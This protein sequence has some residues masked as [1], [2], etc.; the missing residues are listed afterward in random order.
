MIG[1]II[2]YADAPYACGAGL[3][4]DIYDTKEDAEAAQWVTNRDTPRYKILPY[5]ECAEGQDE[6]LPPAEQGYQSGYY[7]T[8]S[9]QPFHVLG[10]D[11]SEETM[12]ALKAMVDAVSKMTDEE[13]AALREKADEGD[14]D[15]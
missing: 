6:P 7:T 10:R 11:M 2:W 14:K 3:D 9:G 12:N 8:E 5:V 13:I 4:G 1:F 15:K